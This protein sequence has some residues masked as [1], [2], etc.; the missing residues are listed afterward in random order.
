VARNGTPPVSTEFTRATREV[1]L[2]TNLDTAMGNMVARID[3]AD[4]E[5]VALSI[6]IQREAGGNL[7]LV[8]NTIGEA[9]RERRQLRDEL[10]VATAQVRASAW[11][12]T[13]LPVAL[14]LLLLVIAPDYFRPMISQ[15]LGLVMLGIGFGLLALGNWLIR[16]L[17]RIR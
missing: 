3:S 9:I 13:G 1:R 17:T 4:L 11:L 16:R 5:L 14:G 10:T 12:I 7:P 2:G 6:R 8:L 15:P